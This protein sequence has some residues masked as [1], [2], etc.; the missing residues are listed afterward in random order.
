MLLSLF[1][2]KIENK[3][4]ASQ[5]LIYRVAHYVRIIGWSEALKRW[6]FDQ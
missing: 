1:S 4:L 3:R 2:N 5:S 6:F